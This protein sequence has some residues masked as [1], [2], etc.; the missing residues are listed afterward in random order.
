MVTQVFTLFRNQILPS[1]KELVLNKFLLNFQ[2]NLC[3]VII[4]LYKN[5]IKL[6]WRLGIYGTL[7]KFQQ[8]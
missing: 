3:Y 6:C 7:Y 8:G 4:I 1:L 2:W 5:K